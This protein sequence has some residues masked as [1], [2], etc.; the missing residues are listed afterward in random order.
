MNS[1]RIPLKPNNLTIFKKNIIFYKYFTRK[2]MLNARG[3]F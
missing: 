3:C 1:K 2:D